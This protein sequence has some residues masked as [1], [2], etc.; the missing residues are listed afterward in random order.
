MLEGWTRLMQAETP[1]LRPRMPASDREE[2]SQER[3]RISV[4]SCLFMLRLGYLFVWL[5]SRE[6]GED[7]VDWD[8]VGSNCSIEN[9]FY[10]FDERISSNNSNWQIWARWGFPAISSHLPNIREAGKGAWAKWAMAMGKKGHSTALPCFEANLP[11]CLPL[12]RSV[13][14]HYH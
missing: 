4:I 3:R 12:Q 14:S 6:G 9:R 11:T 13:G 7:T 2:L 5:F 8:A 10:D 1:K